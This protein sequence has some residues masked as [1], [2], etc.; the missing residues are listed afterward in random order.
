MQDYYIDMIDKINLFVVYVTEA[1]AS[2]V[3]NIGESAGFF[4]ESHKKI[5]DRIICADKLKNTFGLTMPIYCDNMENEFETKY[6]SWP[7]RYYIIR[8]G[9]FL[10][11]GE[12]VDDQF[13]VCELF[14]FVRKQL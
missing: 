14:Q 3:W 11:I 5:E 4:V 13:D 9:K 2:D 7:F 6:A 8:N 1:H 12:P 10:M